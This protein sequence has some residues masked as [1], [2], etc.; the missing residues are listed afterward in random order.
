MTPTVLRQL[1]S[2]VETTQSHTLLRL[3]DAHLIQWLLKQTKMKTSLNQNELDVLS[4]YIR[5]RLNL[6]RDLA[7]NRQ[8]S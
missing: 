6:I 4:D 7:E 1:W 3:D 8:P 2:V 5:S